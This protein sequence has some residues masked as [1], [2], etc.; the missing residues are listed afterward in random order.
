[1]NMARFR[2]RIRLPLPYPIPNPN[3]VDADQFEN[4]VGHG[5][6]APNQ[7]PHLPAPQRG[8]GV[9]A[10]TKGAKNLFKKKR[11]DET[12]LGGDTASWASRRRTWTNINSCLKVKEL[13]GGAANANSC[14]K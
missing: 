6:D 13:V 11:G 4:L 7:H 1:M 3:Q 2:A 8:G 10:L 9:T 5:R 14:F 12:V